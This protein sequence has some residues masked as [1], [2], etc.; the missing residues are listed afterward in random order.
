LINQGSLAH[1][2]VASVL[3]GC[4]A[5]RG[6][7]LPNASTWL[8]EDDAAAATPV[9]GSSNPLARSATAQK[10]TAVLEGMRTGCTGF[11]LL[12]PSQRLR[13]LTLRNGPGHSI[14]KNTMLGSG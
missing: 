10:N 11:G 3:D 6:P 13:G 12:S 8:G 5:R 7:E 1:D 2:E 4:H 14:L 9:D